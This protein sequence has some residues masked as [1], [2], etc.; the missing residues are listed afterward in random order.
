MFYRQIK[1]A[2]PKPN[3]CHSYRLVVLYDSDEKDGFGNAQAKDEILVYRVAVTLQ[4]SNKIKR[5]LGSHQPGDA[6]QLF[7]HQ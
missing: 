7:G 6:M 3:G 4:V 5:D 1:V 2:E